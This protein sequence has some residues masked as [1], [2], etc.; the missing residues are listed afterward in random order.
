MTFKLQLC[1]LNR[2]VLSCLVLLLLLL[3]ASQEGPIEDT[4]NSSIST[5]SGNPAVQ[6]K[7]SK[8]LKFASKGVA[9]PRAS[10]RAS[11]SSLQNVAEVI[12]TKDLGARIELVE[13]TLAGLVAMRD[14]IHSMK[15]TGEPWLDE[16]LEETKSQ[17]DQFLEIAPEVVGY[18]QE[19]LEEQRQ[20]RE[21]LASPHEK[22]RSL[23]EDQAK[24]K[25]PSVHDAADPKIK[26]R[27]KLEPPSCKSNH[28]QYARSHH[29]VAKHFEGDTKASH[30][31]R[32]LVDMQNAILGGDHAHL[33][34]MVGSMRGKMNRGQGSR[35][36]SDSDAKAKQCHLLTKCAK[37]F[38]YYDTIVFFYSD[39]I[40]PATG[41]IDDSIFHFDEKHL[42]EKHSDIH[43]VA[44]RLWGKNGDNPALYKDDPYTV[45][46]C[47]V[48]MQHFHRNVEWEGVPH[49]EGGEHG[50]SLACGLLLDCFKSHTAL[51]IDCNHRHGF[52]GLLGPGLPGLHSLR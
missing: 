10:L 36:L 12:R 33:S 47:A 43:T 38:S 6:G 44:S 17:V 8:N 41:E 20:H 40:D 9:S 46:S 48:L 37:D 15:P 51:H 42:A 24:S 29:H 7:I 49:W 11:L 50:K 19:S 5:E 34:K 18:M 4:V 16:T 28:G 2:H 31:H 39:D 35:R 22:Q 23:G 3:Q 45:Y 14:R 32:K 27:T 1:S 21:K 26:H 52:T 30:R 25:A 13:D